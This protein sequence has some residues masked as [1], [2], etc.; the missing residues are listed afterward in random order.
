[1]IPV[2]NTVEENHD[3][4]NYVFKKNLPDGYVYDLSMYCYYVF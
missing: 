3:V 1:M 4:N 2:T